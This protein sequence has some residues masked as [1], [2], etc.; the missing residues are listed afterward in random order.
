MTGP[1]ARP[2][3]ITTIRSQGAASLP[4]ARS[5]HLLRLTLLRIAR[6]SLIPNYCGRRR[7]CSIAAISHRFPFP[8]L[9]GSP[10]DRGHEKFRQTPDRR[11]E[12]STVERVSSDCLSER[13]PL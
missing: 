12:P 7:D 5:L 8:F 6:P 11:S 3:F 10:P 9:P 2:S 4:S 13:V 1:R